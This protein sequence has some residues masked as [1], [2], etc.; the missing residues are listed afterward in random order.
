MQTRGTQ[1]GLKIRG[2]S[3]LQTG[4]YPKEAKNK[5]APLFANRGVPKR[6]EK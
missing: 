2:P 4:G 5:R 1:R 3:Y 6:V